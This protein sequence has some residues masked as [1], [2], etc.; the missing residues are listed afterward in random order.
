MQCFAFP[1]FDFLSAASEFVEK[2]S[3]L[4]VAKQGAEEFARAHVV[5]F[6]DRFFYV[7][8]RF[9]RKG[10]IDDVSHMFSGCIVIFCITI[11]SSAFARCQYAEKISI[12]RPDH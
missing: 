1:G 12:I 4:P 6:F 3:F 9:V 10:D 7:P 8:D 11:V 2:D 5:T